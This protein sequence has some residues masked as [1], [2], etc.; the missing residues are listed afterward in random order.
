[1]KKS[2]ILI[3]TARGAVVDEQALIESLKNND[4]NG[5]GLDVFEKEPFVPKEL[6]NLSNV[7]SLPHIGSATESTRN[8]MIKLAICNLEEYLIN[9]SFPLNSVNSF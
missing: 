5:A 1:M 7:V 6:L 9:K 3:N 8:N 2:A 4:I